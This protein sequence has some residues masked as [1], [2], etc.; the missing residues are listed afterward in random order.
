MSVLINGM[1]MPTSC[2]DCPMCY[3]MMQ[4]S[5]AEPIINFFKVKKEFDFCAERH[6][7]C[8]LVEIPSHGRL[9]DADK[10]FKDICNS[11][12][13]M[14]TIGIAVDGEWMW[15][16]LIDALGNAPTIIPAE[17]GE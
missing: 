10:F 12:N 3:D 6:P 8:P 2:N 4:C 9:I 1:K 15:G 14:T 5:I 16:K 7:R 17:E 13:E 11:L